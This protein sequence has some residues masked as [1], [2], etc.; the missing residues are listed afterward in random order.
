MMVGKVQWC[1]V[2]GKWVCLGSQDVG[3]EVLG[4]SLL[5]GVGETVW[6]IPK[7]VVFVYCVGGHH[8]RACPQLVCL[9]SVTSWS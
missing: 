2:S 4:R 1:R 6:F 8:G 9:G 5:M 7:I 3:R